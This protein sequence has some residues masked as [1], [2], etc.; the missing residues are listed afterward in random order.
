MSGSLIQE[1]R[2]RL[3]FKAAQNENT[4][5]G[6]GWNKLALLQGSD[7]YLQVSEEPGLTEASPFAALLHQQL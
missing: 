3:G 2:I 1:D 6:T 4:K 5:G 7:H